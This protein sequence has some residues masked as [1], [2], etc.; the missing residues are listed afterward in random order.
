LDFSKLH[1][2]PANNVKAAK[3]VRSNAASREGAER[4]LFLQKS[5]SFLVAAALACK[6]VGDALDT[7]SFEWT[8][9]SPDWSVID[10]QIVQFGLDRVE[11]PSIAP[12]A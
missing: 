1:L 6:A 12:S 10:A 5:N 11:A 7:S 3:L 8:A 4:A 2:T 9:L